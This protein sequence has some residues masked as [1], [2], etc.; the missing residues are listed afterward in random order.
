MSDLLISVKPNT[1][2]S[3]A[4]V[5]IIAVGILGEVFSWP[6]LWYGLTRN[7]IGFTVFVLG[8]ALHLYC[9]KYHKKAHEAADHVQNVVSSG[10]FSPIRHPMY[11]DL[12]LMYFGLA[13]G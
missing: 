11:L 9:Y 13:V 12:I 1:F 10:P 8:W 5:I 3:F 6:V 4:F 2:M 7:I